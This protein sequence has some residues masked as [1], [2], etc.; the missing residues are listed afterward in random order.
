M[1][2][3]DEKR[4]QIKALLATGMSKNGVAKACGVSWATVEIESKKEPD[5]IENFREQ[6][7]MQFVDRIWDS[8]D[9]ALK[10][11]DMRIKLAKD[12]TEKLEI[13]IDAMEDNGSVDP[14][15]IQEVTRAIDAITSIPLSHISTY[16]GTLYDKQALMTSGR[17]EEKLKKLIPLLKQ[18]NLSDDEINELV[19]TI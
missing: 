11:G 7:R 18:L 17:A 4:E 12:G 5:K 1:A 8:M 10:L 14:R 3:S 15:Q 16:F 9:E 19:A 13:L 2:L 6:K